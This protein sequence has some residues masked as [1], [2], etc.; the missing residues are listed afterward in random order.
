LTP[1]RIH[2]A[3]EGLPKTLDATYARILESIPKDHI[4][5]AITILML[6]VWSQRPLRLEEMADAIA[7]DLDA[8]PAFDPRDR[9]S[10]PRDV[11]RLCRGLV[12]LTPVVGDSVSGDQEQDLQLQLAHSSVRQFLLS[13]RA[14]AIIRLQM[15]QAFANAQFAK[16]CLAY[17]FDVTAHSLPLEGMRSEFP[18]AQYSARYWSEHAR[19]V[20]ATDNVLLGVV[21]SFLD[22]GNPAFGT[23]YHLFDPDIPQL[24]TSEDSASE[25]PD[26]LYIASLQGLDQAVENL[27]ERGSDINAESGLYG[28]P[29]QAASFAGYHGT[30]QILLDNGA[31]VN[32][33]GGKYGNALQAASA[34]GHSSILEMLL[35]NGADV[36][37]RNGR[38]GTALH[39]ALLNGSYEMVQTLLDMGADPNAQDEFSGTALYAASQ[40]GLDQIVQNLID[41]GADP[42]AR[43]GEY[44]TALQVAAFKGHH[45]IVQILV[46]HG[47]DVNAQSHNHGTAF[48]I[49]SEG[50]HKSIVH[51][52]LESGANI[53]TADQPARSSKYQEGHSNVAYSE[54]HDSGYSSCQTQSVDEYGDEDS[55]PLDDEIEPVGSVETDVQ[56]S[57]ESLAFSNV[58]E[59]AAHEIARTFIRD[60]EISKL[61]DV[62]RERMGDSK[63]I[64]N[65]RRLLKLF[66]LEAAKDA[67]FASHHVV[68]RFLRSRVARVRISARIIEAK[69][70]QDD[71]SELDIDRGQSLRLI[72]GILI[73]AD[74]RRIQAD[75]RRIQADKRR[76][77]SRWIEALQSG[78]KEQ[79]GI[80]SGSG[81]DTWASLAH[82]SPVL[83]LL[84]D[85]LNEL[86]DFDDEDFDDLDANNEEEAVARVDD[87]F[88]VPAIVKM[89]EFLMG[90]RA[91]R[92]YKSNLRRFAHGK[93]ILPTAFRI[94]LLADDLAL[95]VE[96]L[97][98]ESE[99]VTQSG[100]GFEW[101]K[102][103]L[104]MGFAPSEVVRLIIRQQEDPSWK[105]EGNQAIGV[106]RWNEA[107][108]LI[109]GEEPGT[110]HRRLITE[111]LIATDH[112]AISSPEQHDD[113]LL[114]LESEPDL[115]ENLAWKQ[116]SGSLKTRT[117]AICL[118]VWKQGTSRIRE[119]IVWSG[120]ILGPLQSGYTRITWKDVSS[121]PYTLL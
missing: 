14:P 98:N 111:Y 89:T 55:Q 29:L 114:P 21:A 27:L 63:F 94:A 95:A 119:S 62:G 3:L 93:R 113:L 97:E 13:G 9:L 41:H 115:L 39:A 10:D 70:S 17:L 105:E 96:L 12:I 42:N 44:G 46:D 86:E 52:L 78:S 34:N 87:L 103:P 22:H 99:A 20:G 101:I 64:E 38:Y 80:D 66:Y 88:H 82:E 75:K 100:L 73:Q 43:G 74:K 53:V 109:R 35:R 5:H 106:G 32:N 26:P 107:R 71:G 15:D 1:S 91:F 84:A 112:Q 37:A 90:G 49:A 48:H 69:D 51:I 85:N 47:A 61:Y 16:I 83:Q 25:L 24:S 40:Q 59:A 19:I 118:D 116:R 81:D 6:M 65:H 108:E 121:V 56:S 45:G 68:V 23:C 7:I 28:N 77:T 72:N 33:Q 67:K 50:G 18:F 54:F 58:R 76:D 57:T 102:E 92:I 11:L 60:D 2:A 120:L 31:G 4:R 30:V 36:N 79:S 117:Q 110:S 8:D 104:A